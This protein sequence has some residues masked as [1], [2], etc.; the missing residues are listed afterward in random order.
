MI[1]LCL[2]RISL[3]AD[4]T[5]CTNTVPTVI[6]N[7]FTQCISKLGRSLSPTKMCDYFSRNFIW[8]ILIIVKHNYPFSQLGYFLSTPY[9]L[10]CCVFATSLLLNRE[11]FIIRI[12]IRND[13]TR[14]LQIHL[15]SHLQWLGFCKRQ[16][17]KYSNNNKC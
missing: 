12:T 4:I 13:S 2:L 17:Y 5:V 15:Y 3:C 16:L 10:V 11:E 14:L 1:F 7:K 9:L 6:V 8:S